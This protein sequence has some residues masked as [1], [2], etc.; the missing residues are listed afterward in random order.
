[1]SREKYPRRNG[2]DRGPEKGDTLQSPEN[3]LHPATESFGGMIFSV[4]H[5]VIITKVYMDYDAFGTHR[6]FSLSIAS[7]RVAR[8]SQ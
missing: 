1:V 7:L 2:L 5:N 3:I 4:I 6:A 8:K